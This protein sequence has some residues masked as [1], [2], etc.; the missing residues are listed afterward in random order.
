MEFEDNSFDGGFSFE[1]TCYA[2]DPVHLYKEI[3][4]VLKPG[5]I[6]VDSAWAMTDKYDPQNPDHVRTKD[7][8]EV[9]LIPYYVNRIEVL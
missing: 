6:F 2:R 1:A 9:I 5:A 7:D 4:R 8:I 3:L